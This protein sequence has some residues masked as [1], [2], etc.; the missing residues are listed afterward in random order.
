L[1]GDDSWL[2]VCALYLIAEQ[3]D[4]KCLTKIGKFMQDPDAIVQETARF[5]K[6]KLESQNVDNR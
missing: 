2:R 5:A 6:K 3:G 1:N 4:E